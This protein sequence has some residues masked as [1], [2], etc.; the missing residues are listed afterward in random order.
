MG[1]VIGRIG[2]YGF[3]ESSKSTPFFL[4]PAFRAASHSA[5]VGCLEESLLAPSAIASSVI[6]TGRLP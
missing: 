4:G 3:G 6:L 1:L 2:V 5:T